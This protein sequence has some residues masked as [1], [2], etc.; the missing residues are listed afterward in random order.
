MIYAVDIFSQMSLMPGIAM[1][2]HTTVATTTTVPTTV[3]CTCKLT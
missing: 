1:N 3:M 2:T